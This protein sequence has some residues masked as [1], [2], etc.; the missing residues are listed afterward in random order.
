MVHNESNFDRLAKAKNIRVKSIG[1]KEAVFYRMEVQ[2]VDDRFIYARCWKSKDSEPVDYK[3][4]KQEVVIE[5]ESFSGAKTANY[6]FGTV[7]SIGLL[8]LLSIL[9]TR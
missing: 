6:L 8:I 9:L 4:N 3:F 2:K 1:G 5:S 7:L